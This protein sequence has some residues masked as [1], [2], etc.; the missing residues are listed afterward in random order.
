[1]RRK[2]SDLNR[3]AVFY[4]GGRAAV[5]FLVV[6][7]F[8]TVLSHWDF[9]HGKS[10]LPAPVKASC[11]RVALPNLRCMLSVLVFPKSTDL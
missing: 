9:S 6:V 11:D 10:G 1:M 3:G 2:K 7:F 5:G 4:Y 8:T